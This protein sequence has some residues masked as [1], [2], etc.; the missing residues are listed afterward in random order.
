MTAVAVLAVLVILG[1]AV[2][3]DAYRY[4]IFVGSSSTRTLP[5][6]ATNVT[7][8]LWGAGGGGASTLYCGAGGGSGAA[9][10]NRTVDTS[11]WANVGAVQ[12]V[13][14]VGQGGAASPGNLG[15]ALGGYGGDGGATTLVALGADSTQLF[16]A[17][18]YGGGGGAALS[19]NATRGCKGG[20]GGGAAS[21]A[22]GTVPGTGTPPGS[23]DN[24]STAPAHEGTTVG[25]IKAGGA[26]AGFG[27]ES[28]DG[29]P[30]V[31]GAGW[32]SPGRSFDSG[33]GHYDY[34]RGCSSRGGAAGFNG[35][36]GRGRYYDSTCWSVAPNTGAG[37]GS[38]FVCGPLRYYVDSPG[39]SGGAIIEYDYAVAPTPSPTPSVTPSRSPTPSPSTTSTPSATPSSQPLTQTGVWFISPIND[40]NLTP[41]DDG[42]VASLWYDPSY[43]SKWTVTRLSNGKYTVKSTYKNCYL[44][45]HAASPDGYVRCE[46]STPGTNGEWTISIAPNDEWT[47]KSVHNTYMGTTS[48]G[49]IYLNQN[50]GLYWTKYSSA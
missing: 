43:H 34:E 37:G 7:V 15:S 46:S 18:A 32:S 20:A 50:S 23:A 44:T 24:D 12:W 38:A 40:K 26:G 42:S 48:G 10:M 8:T 30:R 25:D 28:Y 29:S 2:P 21:S 16:S 4:T 41:Q 9:I 22:Q 49:V 31:N 14:T 17:T 6:G 45:G 36:G 27:F 19:V 39:S 47:F 5:A 11:A 13:I 33:Y 1:L 3:I 35:A